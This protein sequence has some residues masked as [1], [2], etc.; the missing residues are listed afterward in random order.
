MVHVR[1]V[2]G[3]NDTFMVIQPTLQEN[4]CNLGT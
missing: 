4:P 1:T 3:S 2:P